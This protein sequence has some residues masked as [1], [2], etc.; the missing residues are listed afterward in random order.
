MEAPAQC[1]KHRRVCFLPIRVN[2]KNYGISRRH[3][4][5]P[6]HILCGNDIRFVKDGLRGVI[7]TGPALQLQQY[8][9]G[10]LEMVQSIRTP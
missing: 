8:M 3:K 2:S 4:L 7:E 10:F 6:G 5:W 1:L 9:S